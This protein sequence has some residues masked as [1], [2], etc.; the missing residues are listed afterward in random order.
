DTM[1]KEGENKY[2]KVELQNNYIHIN[3]LQED[4]RPTM[5]NNILPHG[6]IF[7]LLTSHPIVFMAIS[8][9][10]IRIG[11]VYI[12]LACPPQWMKQ[13]IQLCTNGNG[14][15]YKGAHFESIGDKGSKGE[16]LYCKKYVEN[17]NSN[18]STNFIP[19]LEEGTC[20]AVRKRGDVQVSNKVPGFL[21]YTR[22]GRFYDTDFIMLGNVISG[23][24]TIDTAIHKHS[25]DLLEI[26]EVGIV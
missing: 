15:T 9:S 3:A 14:R 2:S 19:S 1:L 16:R 11:T 6:I 22:E 5:E 24:E 7:G 21:I 4:V 23:I 20:N 10:N 18:S 8:A 13:I 17:G 25:I 26:C 12:K